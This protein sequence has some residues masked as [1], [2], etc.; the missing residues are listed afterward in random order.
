[1]VPCACGQRTRGV[2]L[3]RDA[4][5][6]FDQPIQAGPHGAPGQQAA[7]GAPVIRGE[8]AAGATLWA[9]TSAIEDGNGLDRVQFRY[10]WI[11]GEGE[12]AEAIT[13]AT[14]PTYIWTE[15]DAE[16]LVSVR[17]SFVDRG[18]YSESLRS[19]EVSEPPPVSSPATGEVTIT[20]TPQVGETLTTDVS[21]VTDADGLTDVEG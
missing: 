2:G 14:Q 8:P 10:Q 17:V 21:E 9:D 16:R 5:H 7:T 13:G 11:A 1:M 3:V 6:E 20:G 4:V 12:D 15:A 18:G 19:E